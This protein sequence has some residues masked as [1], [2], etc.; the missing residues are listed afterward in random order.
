LIL[1]GLKMHDFRTT[2]TDENSQNFQTGYLLSEGRVEAGAALFNKAKVESGRESNRFD[3][4]AWIVR[5]VQF[6][7]ISGNRSML[8]SVQTGDSIREG[9]AKIGVGGAAIACPPTGIHAEL[10]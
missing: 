3:V 2:D 6:V 7:I 10:G 1:P 9:R 8:P 5:I 4:V